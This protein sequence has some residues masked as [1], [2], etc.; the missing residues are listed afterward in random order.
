M[1]ATM[2]KRPMT[3][4]EGKQTKSRPVWRCQF[5]ATG[6]HRSCPRATRQRTPKG[7]VLWLCKCEKGEHAGLHCLEC[8]HDR[9]EDVNPETWQCWDRHACQTI[10][11][12]RRKHS[13]LWQMIQASKSHGALIRKA[14]RMDL[15][16][17]LAGVDVTQ[18]EKIERLHAWL[19]AISA[20]R[21]GNTRARKRT[22]GAP[23]RARSGK[24]ECCG[25][26]T[27]GGRFLP[28]HDAK[29]ASQLKAKVQCGDDEA[30]AEME[31]RGW[32]NKLPGSLRRQEA[33]K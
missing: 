8:K 16:H 1:T 29:L 32:L 6:N 15:E 30:Y 28:G 12:N 21:A 13:R 23:P 25:E 27:K 7:E 20:S 10:L 18:D 5:C 4:L 14:K 9:P 22:G 17:L 24:C 3:R 33:S 26:P 2:A 19:D 11:D 31:R